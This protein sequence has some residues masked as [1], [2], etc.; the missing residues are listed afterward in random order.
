[1]VVGRRVLGAFVSALIAGVELPATSS[2]GGE[3]RDDDKAK[4]EAAGVRAFGRVEGE[5]GAA[6]KAVLEGVLQ[7]ESAGWCE[8]QTTV[9]RRAQSSILQNEEDWSG[10]ADALMHIPLDGGSR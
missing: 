10:A 1:M 5:D 3:E 8:E 9:M 2:G 6:R 4:W 7:G